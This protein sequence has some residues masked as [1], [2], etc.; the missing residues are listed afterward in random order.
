[1]KLYNL[2]ENVTPEIYSGDEFE[3]EALQSELQI[4]GCWQ[5]ESAWRM[6]KLQTAISELRFTTKLCPWQEW[7]IKY[8]LCITLSS[9]YSMY[10]AWVYH[11]YHPLIHA[12]TCIANVSQTSLQLHVNCKI[13]SIHCGSN[14]YLLY[15]DGLKL[16]ESNS[17]Y[18]L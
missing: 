12:V 10:A 11:T 14:T 13:K 16:T 5:S 3:E 15:T 7:C 8:W 18:R 6:C 2:I 4:Y 1:M 9:C 17:Y